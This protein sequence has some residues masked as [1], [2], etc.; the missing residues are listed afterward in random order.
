MEN[1]WNTVGIA[2]LGL[3]GGSMAKTIKRCM[4]GCQVAGYDI[5][6]DV[7]RKAGQDHALDREGLEAVLSSSL[8]LV[9]LYPRDTVEFVKRYGEKMA[10][11]TVV[12]D[13][14]GVKGMVCQALEPYCRQVGLRFVGGHPMAG[15]EFSGYDYTL[16]SLFTG[17]SMILTPREG[18]DPA[19]VEALRGFFYR[20]EFAKVVV[21]T[22]QNHDKMIAFTSQLAHVVSNA[23]VKSPEAD[24][25]NGYS[26]GSYKDLTRV[27]RLNQDMWTQ[28]FLCNRQALLEELDTLM[29]NLGQVRRAL[30]QGDQDSLRELLRQGSER[31]KAIDLFV[32]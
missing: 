30:V 26:A 22:A 1:Q 24:R 13:L 11:G 19:L 3:I 31:K 14:C 16:P 29:E 15:R 27:A 2:G 10:P 20:L 8:I 6:P 18:E 21:T 5:D 17:A 23:Y 4:P 12:V 32:E 9:A 28:L 7:E 25:H